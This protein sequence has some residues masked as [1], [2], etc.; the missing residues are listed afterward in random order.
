MYKYITI[1]VII[2]IIFIKNFLS[3]PFFGLSSNEAQWLH[4]L[5]KNESAIVLYCF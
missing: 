3:F 1:V 5:T 4:L 2:F